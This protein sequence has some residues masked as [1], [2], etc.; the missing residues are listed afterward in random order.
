MSTVKLRTMINVTVQKEVIPFQECRH[1][2]R[3]DRDFIEKYYLKDFN[4]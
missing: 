2:E 3:Y 1:D 4:V